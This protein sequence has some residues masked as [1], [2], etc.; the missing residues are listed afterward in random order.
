[1]VAL[2]DRIVII[3]QDEFCR[4][5]L[6]MEKHANTFCGECTHKLAV[7]CILRL[8]SDTIVALCLILGMATQPCTHL[9][10]SFRDFF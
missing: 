2:C 1:M 9:I 3:N 5:I 10:Q 6:S 4:I 8:A 7:P